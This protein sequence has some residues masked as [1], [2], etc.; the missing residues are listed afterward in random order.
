MGGGVL[1]DVGVHYVSVMRLWLGAVSTVWAATPPKLHPD[2]QGEDAITAL[3][4]FE[5]GAVADLSISWS[6][7]R[8]PE[9]PNLEIIGERGSL[10]LW[11]RR[12][13]V[14]HSA[15]LAASHWSWA[16]QRLLPWRLEHRVR[17]YLPQS[18]ERRIPVARE[19][20]IGST[21]LLHDFV[22]AITTGRPPAV[23]GADGLEDLRVVLAAY[24][25]LESGQ[26]VR[27]LRP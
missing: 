1:L 24:E 15:P 9:T 17:P 16:L 3:L 21:A 13:Y 14:S 7:F 27:I 4:Q 6:G 18:R 19:D 23:P 22:D 10:R 2:L 11:F 8:S 25:A 20:L 12:P 26:P 5:G